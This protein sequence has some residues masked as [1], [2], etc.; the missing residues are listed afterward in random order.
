MT[1]SELMTLINLATKDLKE[2]VCTYHF[3]KDEG[4]YLPK[5][6]TKNAIKRRIVQ[7][8]ADL[9]ELAKELDEE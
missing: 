9:L 4:Q 1:T 6:C 3:H 2:V 5:C 7:L 8:R